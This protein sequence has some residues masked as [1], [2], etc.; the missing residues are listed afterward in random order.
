METTIKI[1]ERKKTENSST[2]C[3]TFLTLTEKFI[4][5][6]LIVRDSK[7]TGVKHAGKGIGDIF[8]YTKVVFE[9]RPNTFD[10]A[11]M[12]GPKSGG[13]TIIF[14]KEISF[15]SGGLSLRH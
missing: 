7:E 1:I 12:C 3:P 15:V 11:R 10:D 4:S 9:L 8:N 5:V 2:F 14:R 13:G 6:F